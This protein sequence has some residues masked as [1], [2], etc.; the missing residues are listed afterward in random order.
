MRTQQW[1]IDTRGDKSKGKNGGSGINRKLNDE[2][3]DRERLDRANGRIFEYLKQTGPGEFEMKFNRLPMNAFDQRI[4][5]VNLF[6]FF[7][8]RV[9]RYD[10]DLVL[11]ELPANESRNI[12]DHSSGLY[13]PVDHDFKLGGN[14]QVLNAKDFLTFV[15]H[16]KQWQKIVRDGGTFIDTTVVLETEEMGPIEV[17]V[18]AELKEPRVTEFD[19]IDFGQIQIG[20]AERADLHLTN[21]TKK[22]VQLQL[23]L[24]Y[25][26]DHELMRAAD[27]DL[28]RLDSYG[29][30][31]VLERHVELYMVGIDIR[32]VEQIDTL[33]E[34][35]RSRHLSPTPDIHKYT[36]PHERSDSIVDILLRFSREHEEAKRQEEMRLAKHTE[37][38]LD[39]G[40]PTYD[41]ISDLLPYYM[42]E[43]ELEA[44]RRRAEEDIK[45]E[46]ERAEAAAAALDDVFDYYLWYRGINRHNFISKYCVRLFQ[47]H[48]ITWPDDDLE[49]ILRSV[50][51]KN[52]GTLK[53]FGDRRNP[54]T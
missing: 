39:V 34:T 21:P 19:D 48:R 30:R 6:D 13:E 41:D 28:L 8:Q 23:F 36:T 24:G 53:I 37:D 16:E 20:Q 54:V 9:S 33:F 18:T 47:E 25:D 49:T 32:T 29:F 3:A 38:L 44:Q 46:A 45:R 27:D 2:I 12:S 22:H 31:E 35:F 15:D 17:P 51:L 1:V 14:Q 4:G 10:S 5:V 50:P 52:G 43:T 7:H 40:Y 42:E 11:R 26:L